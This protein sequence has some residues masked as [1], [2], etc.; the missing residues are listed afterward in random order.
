MK[1]TLQVDDD[2]MDFGFSTVSEAE[3]KDI[4]KKLLQEVESKEVEL[5]KIEKDY[6]TRLQK[7]HKMIIPLLNNLAKDPDKEYIHWP[8][9][10]KKIEEFRKKI[11]KLIEE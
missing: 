9:R 7:L 8:N 11:D 1:Q 6:K 10:T 2:A 4:E 5:E 3:L